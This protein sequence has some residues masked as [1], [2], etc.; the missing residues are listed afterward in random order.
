MGD[1]L[2]A[3][4]ET[5]YQ[6][7]N[8]PRPIHPSKTWTP[9]VDTAKGEIVVRSE[10]ADGLAVNW[11]HHLRECGL[12]PAAF[13]VEEPAD[14][15]T[16]DTNLGGGVTQRFFYFKAKIWR[17]TNPDDLSGIIAEIRKH[18]PVKT[19]PPRGAHT[20]VV[21]L[22]DWQVGKRDGDGTQGVVDAV[23]KLCDQ[24]PAH[25]RYLRASGTDVGRL[26]ILGLGDLVEGCTGS[27]PSQEYRIDYDRRDQVKIARRLVLKLCQTWAPLF[28]E[29]T[30]AAVPGNHGENKKNGRTFTNPGDN[31]DV[32][33]VEQ[34]AEI[35]AANPGRY[36]HIKTV[37][38]RDDISVLLELS[39]VGVALAHGHVTGRGTQADRAWRWWKDQTHGRQP[40][41]EADIL[42]TGHFHHLRVVEQGPRTW[43]QAPSLDSSEWFQQR[44]GY[45]S[46]N[47]VLTFTCGDGGWDNLKVLR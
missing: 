36:G 35:L 41:G 6:P 37:I 17:R 1:F 20:L 13:V 8:N 38:P 45:G 7:P 12:D 39:G 34:V 23:L 25:V 43:L 28:S 11:D 22:A 9:G 21:A 18:R 19:K 44:Y 2:D 31:D 30:L 42:V 32:A 40:A 15:R 14:V 3:L 27:Y 26:S 4:T 46:P 5:T 47:G 24:V 29:V 16:W 33:L 10:N